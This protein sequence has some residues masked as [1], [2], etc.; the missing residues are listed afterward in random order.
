M[1]IRT[2][3]FIVPAVF[4]GGRGVVIYA[5]TQFGS[6]GNATAAGC[7]AGFVSSAKIIIRNITNA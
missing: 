6:I 4:S 2:Q 5:T 1:G 7:A 3:F